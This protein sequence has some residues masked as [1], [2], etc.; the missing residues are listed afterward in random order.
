VFVHAGVS[1]PQPRWLEML[2]PGGRIALSLTAILPPSRIRRIIRDHA[3]WVL[4]AKRTEHGF[5]ARFFELIGVQALLGGRDSAIQARLRAAYSQ[6]R[7][8][9][10]PVASLRTDRHAR[11]ASC[12]LHEEGFCLSRNPAA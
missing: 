7:G 9:R 10:P 11:D 8:A 12:W 4:I 3:G 6:E 1:H 5:A 2:A